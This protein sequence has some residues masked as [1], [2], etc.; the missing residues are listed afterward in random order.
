MVHQQK[1]SELTAAQKQELN[2]LWKHWSMRLSNAPDPKRPQRPGILKLSDS[3][4]PDLKDFE[5]W[6]RQLLYHQVICVHRFLL[7]D[8]SVP[9]WARKVSLLA[10]HDMGTGKTITAIGAIAGLYKIVPRIEDF[11]VLVV[12]PLTVL[13]TWYETLQQWTTLGINIVKVE[14]ADQITTDTLKGPVVMVTTKDVL[15]C[16]YK[17][18]MYI[19]PDAEE[20]FTQKGERKTRPGWVP[21]TDPAANHSAN[22]RLRRKKARDANNGVLPA[23]PLFAH[24]DSCTNRRCP[25]LGFPP[26][27]YD[28]EY[29][30]VMTHAFSLAIV[31]EIHATSNPSTQYGE[32]LGGILKRCAY[33][34]ALTGTPVRSKPSQCADICKTINLQGRDGKLAWLS[35]RRNWSVR[36][37]G[38]GSIRP[39][40]INFFHL[41]GCDRVD[42]STIDLTLKTHVIV[43]FDPWIGRMPD[44]TIDAAQ[45]TRHNAYLNR[46]QEAALDAAN[47]GA[48]DDNYRTS[49]MSFFNSSAQFCMSGVLGMNTAEAFG[50]NKQLYEEALKQ[51]SEQMRII[52]RMLRD[53]Q[54][55]G[56]G[57][58]VVYSESV[59]MLELL[60]NQLSVWGECG[61]LSLFT[62]KCT[63][64]QRDAKVADF[65]SPEAPR[66]VL[67]ISEAGSVGTTLCPGCDTLFVVGDIPWTSAELTQA[68][69]R[70]HRITQDKN[71]EIVHVVPRRS[72]I[73]IKYDAHREEETKLYPAIRDNDFTNFD[74]GLVDQWRSRNS[75]TLDMATVNNED[76]CYGHSATEKDRLAQWQADY[77]SAEANGDPLP[78]KPPEL[79]IEDPVLADD[80]DIQEAWPCT[81]PV[82]GFVEPP[83]QAYPSPIKYNTK[84][85]TVKAEKKQKREEV[86][87]YDTDDS[88]EEGAAAIQKTRKKPRQIPQPM[89]K[90]ELD[91][92]DKKRVA[93][94]RNLM[95]ADE[96]TSEETSDAE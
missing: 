61:K 9:Y 26:G 22:E 68:I 60:V 34:L 25:D 59:V 80:C 6:P 70:V 29:A 72:I 71:V 65:L 63:L 58:I 48:R 57:R 47:G 79:V 54:R 11:R 89:S 96:E 15:V 39:D 95:F 75:A 33:V 55:K 36:G 53:R 27:T 43:E 90:E 91:A 21:G 82:E 20:W 44:G 40:T 42:D 5:N 78:E 28:T 46:A 17:T 14:K 94:M 83:C 2:D 16:A 19:Q 73:K 18:F 77:L 35:E 64:S 84:A 32:I 12:A 10:C 7:K 49:L 50:R 62:G 41:H 24:I 31:D 66:G 3:N 92:L 38:K 56:H 74:E 76:G 4:E 67:C 52:W 69:K 1:Y 81:Y 86:S 23:H 85:V 45:I 88:L 87:D 37:R 93:A 30:A 13:T 8:I 51:P